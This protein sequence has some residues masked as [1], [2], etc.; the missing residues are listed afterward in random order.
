MALEGRD[1]IKN[2]PSTTHFYTGEMPKYA[3]IG[4]LKKISA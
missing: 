2:Y 4:I 3:K 1:L